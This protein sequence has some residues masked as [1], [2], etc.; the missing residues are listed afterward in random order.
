M[1]WTAKITFEQFFI[2][3]FKSLLLITGR[4]CKHPPGAIL[5]KNFL[6]RFGPGKKLQKHHAKTSI[7]GSLYKLIKQKISLKVNFWCIDVFFVNFFHDAFAA[8][9]RDQ[10]CGKKFWTGPRGV[11]KKSYYLL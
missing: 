4:P 8:S 5:F 9:S 6:H 10:I 7:K 2:N 3:L 1:P 11:L